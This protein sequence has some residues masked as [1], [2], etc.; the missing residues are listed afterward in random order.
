MNSHGS[1]TA[2]ATMSDTENMPARHATSARRRHW[3]WSAPLVGVLLLTALMGTGMLRSQDPQTISQVREEIHNIL[4]N[5]N[6]DSFWDHGG[7]IGPW[8]VAAS[9]LDERTG[10]LRDFRLTS[11][12]INLG[13][14]RAR[15][16]IDASRNTFSFELREVVIVNVPSQRD[17]D[18]TARHLIPLDSFILGPA[19]YHRKI[20]PD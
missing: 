17:D 16:T 1:Q 7:V 6:G 18:A 13:A 2:V 8:H 19:K 12:S 10:E 20:A 4:L 3:R 9:S 14:S 11:G 15:L 5:K